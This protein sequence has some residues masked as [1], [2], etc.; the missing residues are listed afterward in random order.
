MIWGIDLIEAA[1]KKLEESQ[2]RYPI[3]KMQGIIEEIFGTHIRSTHPL[4][5]LDHRI[6][7]FCK[8]YLILTTLNRSS[9]HW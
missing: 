5:A 6:R 8:K 7:L 2:A 1:T 9:S 4:V 3:E